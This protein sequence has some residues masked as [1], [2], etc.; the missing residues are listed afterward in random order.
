M[1]GRNQ[2]TKG[3][4]SDGRGHRNT[5]QNQRKAS[6]ARLQ[7]F[8]P[9]S[10]GQNPDYTF[11]EVNRALVISLGKKGLESPDDIC[12]A[13]KQLKVYDFEAE[14]PQYESSQLTGAAAKKTDQERLNMEFTRALKKWDRRVE[15]YKTNKRHAHSKIIED[16]CTQTM[17]QKMYQEPDYD[18]T[19][20]SNP[21]ELLKRI[22]KFM[23][24]SDDT[25]W[26]F[27]ELIEAIRRFVNCHQ[28]GGET[29]SDY[30]KRIEAAAKSLQALLGD[31]A[32][33]LYTS[34]SPRDQRGSRMPSSA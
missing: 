28:K 24:C 15:H 12:Q 11:E 25:D 16:Y 14:E 23:T 13:I 21:I 32:C 31:E 10:R 18:T 1:P 20:N 6:S 34:P 30:R 7:K 33:L 29:A 8:H 22:K 5:N 3:G 26:P 17:R 19:L 9:F 2:S 4:R 27:F